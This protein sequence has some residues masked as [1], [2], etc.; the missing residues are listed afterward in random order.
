M[1]PDILNIEITILLLMFSTLVKPILKCIHAFCVY[2]NDSE[3]CVSRLR[4]EYLLVKDV[5]R[6]CHKL[7]QT[8]SRISIYV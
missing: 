7:Q 3:L 8:T 4:M 2:V 1:H 6:K 5:A